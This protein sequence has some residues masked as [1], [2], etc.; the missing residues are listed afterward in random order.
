[1]KPKAPKPLPTALLVLSLALNTP[2]Y[3]GVSGDELPDIG[4]STGALITPAQEQA[5]GRA[6]MRSVRQQ[7]RLVDDPDIEGYVVQLGQRL[8][9][10]SDSPGYP[11]TFF[12][13]D[14]P[15]IN[16]FAGPGGYIG[17][18]TGLLLAARNE[19]ELAGVMAHEI[20]HVT[21]R[22]LL[23]AYE[24][25]QRMSLPT[26]A[27]MIAAILLGAATSSDAGIAAATAIQAGSIQRQL[28][29]TRANEKEADRIG[30]QILARTG[31]DPYGMPGFFER[32]QATTRLY[33]SRMPE[34][35]STHPVTTSRIAESLAR[36]EQYGHQGRRDS[37]TFQLVRARLKVLGS[38]DPA[39]TLKE[40]EAL[41]NKKD[42]PPQ[43][44]YGLALALA[45]NGDAGRA[46]RLLQALLRSDPDRIIYRTSLAELDIDDGRPRQGLKRLADTL[47]L[48]PGD[49]T[50]SRYYVRAL[51]QNGQAEKARSLVLDL[52]KKQPRDT[53]ALYRLL[54]QAASATNRPW[55]TRAATAEIYYMRG[56]THA[57]ISQLK[58]ALGYKQL[59]YYE[60]ARLEARLNQFSREAGDDE[61][62]H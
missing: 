49:I 33:G 41:A 17:V 12:V 26:A 3:A 15:T 27:A 60:R 45:R 22:H 55:E 23:R 24:A 5:L 28:N 48:Y 62:A 30:I 19:S 47:K 40:F 37:L 50:V 13:V 58:Q 2:G 29:F 39:R 21:Q 43:A 51:L 7:A 9:A 14:D 46:R 56:Q 25:T 8:A 36:A 32:L 6:F 11:F 34:F 31:V 20:A 59:D 52:L 4:D 54:A 44:R 18:H 35:L 61:Q 42:A 16:A 38:S 53:P 10:N 1:M 57:A